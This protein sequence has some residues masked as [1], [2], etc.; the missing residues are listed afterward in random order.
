MQLEAA[1]KDSSQL[2]RF[3]YIQIHANKI[4]NSKDLSIFYTSK[5]DKKLL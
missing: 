1:K 4:D 5:K 3:N 2:L